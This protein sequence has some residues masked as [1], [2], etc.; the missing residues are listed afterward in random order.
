MGLLYNRVAGKSL[1]RLEAL[2]DGV[3]AFAMT[4]LVLNLHVPFPSARFD[5]RMLWLALV[6]L[7]PKV[8]A[9][10]MSFMTLGIFW[11]GQQ[12]QF[13]CLERADRNL[14]W[15]HVAFLLAVSLTPFSTALLGAFISYRVALLVYWF[16]IFML[17]ATLF[18]SWRYAAHANL[19]K[20]DVPA[21][22]RAAVVR[23][24]VVAQALYAAAAALCVVNTYVSIALIVGLQLNYVVAPKVGWL[25]KL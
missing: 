4:L 1:H 7:F 19:V 22:V 14:A 5:E 20:D 23:R 17:G 16:D 2:S 21:D 13:N 18:A 24:I 9:W 8:V 11:L 12:A 3:F 15:L 6:A 25:S 10:L